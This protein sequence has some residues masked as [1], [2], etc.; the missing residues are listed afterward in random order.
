VGLVVTGISQDGNIKKLEDALKN[1]GLPLD[2]IQVVEPDDSDAHLTDVQRDDIVDT[3]LSL[4]GGQGTGVP[5]LSGG[6]GGGGGHMGLG[7]S[8]RAYF[9]NEALADRLGDFEIPDS[10]V[11][12]YVEALEAGRSVVAYFAH[13]ETLA[14]VEEIFRASGLA[15]I[16]TF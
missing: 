4:G 3:T 11:E 16:K 14:K 2:P 5:G 12:N 9:R 13:P 8:H 7:T 10:E 15:K 6:G 1:A